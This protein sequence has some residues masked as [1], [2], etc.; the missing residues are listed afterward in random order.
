MLLIVKRSGKMAWCFIEI[1]FRIFFGTSFVTN[2]II[3]ERKMISGKMS[4]FSVELANDIRRLF[5]YLFVLGVEGI[6]SK[7]PCFHLW[8]RSAH[9]H[10]FKLSTAPRNHQLF[11][12][13]LSPILCSDYISK[14]QNRPG[15]GWEG[16]NGEK[17]FAF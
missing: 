10:D 12:R 13:F 6:C 3:L 2:K 7:F 8:A 1:P 11:S 14:E 17:R 15:L 16:Q 5:V 4:R 9:S